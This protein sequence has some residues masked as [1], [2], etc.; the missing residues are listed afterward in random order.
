MLT[1]IR[2]KIAAVSALCLVAALAATLIFAT[3]S[4]ETTKQEVTS[5]TSEQLSLKSE[6]ELQAIAQLEATRIAAKMTESLGVSLGIRHTVESYIQVNDQVALERARLTEWL[7]G[8]LALNPAIIGTY[9]AWEPNA[10]DGK[11]ELFKKE[12][13]TYVN[14]QFAPYWSRSGSNLA[15]RPLNLKNVFDAP[16]SAGS[17]WYTCPQREHRL[18]L[19]EPYSWEVQGKT[20]VG[21]SITMPLMV[22]GKYYGMAGIDIALA[23]IQDIATEAANRLYQGKGK[24]IVLSNSGLVAGH[25]SDPGLIGKKLPAD[26]LGLISSQLSGGQ[27]FITHHGD[28]YVSL[29]AIRIPGAR[30]SWGVVVEIPKSVVLAGVV[31][32]EQVLHSNF[33]AGL[34]Q[35]TLIGS[36]IAVLGVLLLGWMARSIATPIAQ[37]ANRVND[38]ASADGDLTQRLDLDRKDEVGDLA[39][40]VNAFIEKTHDIVKDIA[41]EM[42]NVENTANRTSEISEQTNQRVQRQR[43]EIEMVAAAINE[44]SASAT[45]VAQSAA[46]TSGAATSAKSAVEEGSSNVYHS[47]DAIRELATEMEQADVIMNQLAEDSENIGKIVEVISGI[48]EQTN[49]LALNAA[50]EAARAGEQGRGFSVVADEVRNLASQTQNSTTEIQTLI[51]QLQTRSRQAQKAMENGRSYT[52]NCIERAESA[53]N[54]LDT[55]VDAIGQINDMTSQIATAADEQSSVSED[56]SRSVVTINDTA[57]ELSHG[58]GEVNQQSGQLFNLIKQLEGKLNRFR[59]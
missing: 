5:L 15:L 52:S 38:L 33:A 30:E 9:V 32:T 4:G 21:T 42:G 45:Q 58:A 19:I 14:G 55:V 31:K 8:L 40:G 10:V 28:N 36:I 59:Y 35:Q 49:L 54:H 51:E 25:S 47:V 43:Q 18:C 2:N 37:T 57:D 13:H 23:Y 44:M 22:N 1:S 56:I 34:T 12:D 39:N 48:S 29:G 26:E 46:D 50:I 24:V 16:N 41:Q 6:A 17:Y 53:A 20:T 7:K 11:D 3:I 27:D